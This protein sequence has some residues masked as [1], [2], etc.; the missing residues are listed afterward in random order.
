MAY[1]GAGMSSIESK[2]ICIEEDDFK[3]IKQEICFVEDS[4]LFSPEDASSSL[5]SEYSN[6][7]LMNFKPDNIL[8]VSNF[9]I[10]LMS[11]FTKLNC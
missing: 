8:T 10:K 11:I 2:E 6:L 7:Q 5:S 9:F 1:L 3:N 4:L